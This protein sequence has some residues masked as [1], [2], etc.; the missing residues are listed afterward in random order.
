MST[1]EKLTRSF[2]LGQ[3]KTVGRH[4]FDPRHE[5]TCTNSLPNPCSMF[6]VRTCLFLI[7]S[8]DDCPEAALQPY[9]AKYKSPGYYCHLIVELE[10][11]S[12]QMAAYSSAQSSLHG[13]NMRRLHF[14]SLI[15]SLIFVVCSHITSL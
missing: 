2:I 9:G 1:T 11:M 13:E 10:A 12:A 3:V 5:Y 6:F 4:G 14:Y 7:S 15:F 8:V